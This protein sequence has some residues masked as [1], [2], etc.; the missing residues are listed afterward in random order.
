MDAAPSLAHIIAVGSSSSET[1]LIVTILPTTLTALVIISHPSAD[2]RADQ[3]LEQVRQRSTMP[4]Q[5]VHTTADLVA[6]TLYLVPNTRVVHFDQHR[7]GGV[8]GHGRRRG[9]PL[10]RHSH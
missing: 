6:G 5:V 8:L 4:L 9:P 3:L 7:I 1:L 2:L 10:G